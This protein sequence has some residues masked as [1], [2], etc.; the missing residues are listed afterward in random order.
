[1]LAIRLRQRHNGRDDLGVLRRKGHVRADMYA[2]LFGLTLRN[3]NYR[4]RL[5]SPLLLAFGD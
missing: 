1:M 4:F 3:R 5:V 2:K